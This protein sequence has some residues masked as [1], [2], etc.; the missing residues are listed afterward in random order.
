M[1]RRGWRGLGREALDGLQ[2]LG[3]LMDMSPAEWSELLKS[4]CISAERTESK[5]EYGEPF[6]HT[7]PDT[8]GQRR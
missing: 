5:P 7:V 8:K 4:D 2:S 1:D 6:V 3:E